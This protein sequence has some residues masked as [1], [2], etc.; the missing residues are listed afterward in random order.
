M[1]RSLNIPGIVPV[2]SGGCRGFAIERGNFSRD[3]P[4][5]DSHAA[6]LV[7]AV[8]FLHFRK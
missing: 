7:L 4:C 5:G 8:L 2:G 3:R 1:P 6:S